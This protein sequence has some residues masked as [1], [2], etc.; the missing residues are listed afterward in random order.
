MLIKAD[1]KTF[2]FDEYTT[3][4]RTKLFSAAH[5][6]DVIISLHSCFVLAID[7]EEVKERFCYV[8]DIANAEDDAIVFSCNIYSSRREAIAYYFACVKSNISDI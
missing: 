7:D 1:V 2:D 3:H 8:V 4:A 6:Q 5:A